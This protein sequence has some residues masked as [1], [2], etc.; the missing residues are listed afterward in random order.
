MDPGMISAQVPS[1][2]EI[3][4]QLSNT[5]HNPCMGVRLQ[6]CRMTPLGISFQVGYSPIL[7]PNNF[8]MFTSTAQHSLEIGRE[9]LNRTVNGL[10]ASDLSFRKHRRLASTAQVDSSLQ[11][12]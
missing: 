8:D 9:T 12:M 5:N 10:L 4:S 6:Y 7:V 3:D 2:V 1:L 11:G